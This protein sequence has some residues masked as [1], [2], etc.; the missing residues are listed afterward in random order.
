MAS[1]NKAKAAYRFLTDQYRSNSPF[2]VEDL[3]TVT[4]CAPRTVDTYISKQWRQIV[5]RRSRGQIRVK[6]EILR[7]SEDA[8]LRLATQ[9]RR[10]FTD[11]RRSMYAE[12]VTYEFLLPLTRETQLRKALDDLFYADTIRQRLEEIEIPNVEQ[13]IPRIDGE[14]DDEFANRV[15]QLI[16]GKFG[17]YSINHVSG[18][19]LAAEVLA[20]REDGGRMLAED[21]RYIIDET[22]ASAR[23]FIPLVSTRTSEQATFDDISFE[24]AESEPAV[25]EEI[26]LVH[27]LFFNLFVEAVV[28]M[29]EGEDVIWL[30][31]EVGQHSYLYTWIR[32]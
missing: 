4:G 12:L 6:A 7:L 14:S 21:A 16:A 5:E 17:G 18:R 25:R 26:A 31:E 11:Y 30:V 13:R 2:N 29:V 9:N 10:I 19:Y 24:N 28:R 1:Q 27:W 23:F 22:T 8:F 32:D 3:I 15:C 20:S